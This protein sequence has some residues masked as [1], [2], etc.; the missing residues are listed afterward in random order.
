LAAII[1]FLGIYLVL[2]MGRFRKWRSWRARCCWL[3][4]AAVSPGARHEVRIG[5]WE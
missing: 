2:A 1:I 5:F 4:G 3:R